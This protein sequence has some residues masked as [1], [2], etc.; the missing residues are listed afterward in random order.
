MRWIPGPAARRHRLADPQVL[1]LVA[2][3][4]EA[5]DL[6]AFDVQGLEG[7]YDLEAEKDGLGDAL[8]GD[9]PAQRRQLNPG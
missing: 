8:E 6:A 7:G 4:V 1:D 2:E 9:P 3:Q 5:A